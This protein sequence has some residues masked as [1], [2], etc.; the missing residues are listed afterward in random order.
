MYREINAFCSE[1]YTKDIKIVCEQNVDFL[2][3][4]LVVLKF[5]TRIYTGVLISP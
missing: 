4:N 5:V 2:K 1:I 3:I